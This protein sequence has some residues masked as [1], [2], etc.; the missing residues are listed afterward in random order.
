M[1]RIEFTMLKL[2]N[3]PSFES[4]GFRNDLA[5][6]LKE[7]PKNER[8]ALHDEAK[9]SEDYWTAW[10]KLKIERDGAE[11]YSERAGKLAEY[12]TGLKIDDPQ[13]VFK[14]A[15]D[16]KR[17]RGKYGLPT[18]TLIVVSI[19]EYESQLR[20]IAHKYKIDIQKTTHFGDFF[21]K[22]PYVEAVNVVGEKRVGVDINKESPTSY[23]LSIEVLE[24]ELIHALQGIQSPRMPIELMEYE[25]YIG[26]NVDM[27]ELE[28]LTDEQLRIFVLETLFGEKIGGSVEHWYQEQSN[29]QGHEVKP[30]WE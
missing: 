10:K 7:V 1:G 23:K 4:K 29:K 9:Q 22:H 28:G 18:Q 3:M 14:I 13:I 27:Q 5:K 8:R 26:G 15:E 21:I 19:S 24:H 6:K 20:A 17:V 2:G 12:L 11:S 16:R 25:A 30:P